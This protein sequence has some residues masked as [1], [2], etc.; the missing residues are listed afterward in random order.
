MSLRIPAGLLPILKEEKRISYTHFPAKTG[1][2]YFYFKEDKEAFGCVALS[3]QHEP[4]Q[5]LAL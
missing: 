5:I 1:G 2:F 3:L 4:R